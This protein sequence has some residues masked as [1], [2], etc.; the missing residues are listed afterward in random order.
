MKRLNDAA[1]SGMD[2]LGRQIGSAA[3]CPPRRGKQVGMFY[4]LCQTDKRTEYFEDLLDAYDVETLGAAGTPFYDYPYGTPFYWGKPLYGRYYSGDEWVMRRHVELLTLAGIDFLV[5]DTTNLCA[6]IPQVTLLMRIL[7]EGLK[8]GIETPKIAF[9]T[10]T[11]SGERI[12]E[13]Y[14]GIYR[15]GV[16]PDTWYRI[17]GK[18]LMIGIAEQTDPELLDFFHFKNSQWPGQPYRDNAFPWIDF[19]WPQTC[20]ATADGQER[21]VSVSV[22]QNSGKTACFGE[23]YFYGSNGCHGRSWHD[24]AAHQTPD[25]YMYGYNFAEQWRGA[26]AIDPDTVFVTGWNE[27]IA[28]VWNGNTDPVAIF[29]CLSPEYSRDIEPMAG[30]FGDAYYLQLIDE[31]RRFKG[32]EP[33]QTAACP[34]ELDNLTTAKVERRTET[35]DGVLADDSLRNVLVKT[36]VQRH[37]DMLEF[38]AET[39]EP[40]DPTDRVGDWMRLYVNPDLPDAFCYC[41]NLRTVSETETVAAR[42]VNGRWQRCGAVPY[43]IE[44]NRLTLSVPAGLIGDPEQV[45]VKWVDSRIH[46]RRPEDFYLYGSVAPIGSLYYCIGLKG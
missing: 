37:G 29:D 20:Y 39:R 33:G 10:N 24:G 19:G 23:N 25:S 22:A 7:D 43:R 36:G 26:R 34:V 5:M 41:L 4:F 16:Y 28:G 8:N 1:L 2:I 38:Y 32:I 42:R 13:L 40:L 14:E 9:Y 12:R 15:P 21:T 6:F 44:G 30:G 18:P 31:V 46:C 11:N 35:C 45:Y 3:D 27:W 17:D